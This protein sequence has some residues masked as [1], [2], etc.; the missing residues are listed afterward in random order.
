MKN[1]DILT[2]DWLRE[3]TSEEVI[4]VLWREA[5]AL[6]CPLA[7]WSSPDEDSRH[8]LIDL[9]DKVS[10]VHP[11]VEELPPGFLFTPYE[12][13]FT[14][15]EARDAK[16]SFLLK[17]HLYYATDS[18]S[19]LHLHTGL[20]GSMAERAEL[21]LK[22]AK[23]NIGESRDPLP[24]YVNKEVPA[25]STGREDYLAL[26]GAA[27]NEIKE[28][29]VQK[30]VCGRAKS[31]PLPENFKALAYFNKLCAN[32]PNAFVSFVS[33]P[34]T[35]SWIGATPEVLVQISSDK[36]F[37]T[38]ALAGTQPAT[39]VQS[40]SDAVWRQKEIEEQALVSRYIINCFKKIRLREFEEW[41]PRTVLAGNLMHLRT[42][43]SVDMEAAD[44][45]RLGSTMLELLHPTSA[46]CGMPRAEAMVFLAEKEQLNRQFFA[47][48]LGPVNIREEV[49]LFVNLRCMQ[50]LEKEVVLYAGAGITGDSL[51]EKEW[52][53]T[54]HKLNTLA[55]LL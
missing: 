25:N 51:P 42:D 55:S 7:L 3:H 44:F 36:I 20:S 40:P 22:N 1:A 54:E 31:L 19:M 37:R 43:F 21:L 50:L 41:G 28:G 11:V 48:F 9:S 8:L 24:F 38:M 14:S 45:P 5:F 10:R 46:V 49:H 17:A 23:T 18:S 34:G 6:G 35:G 53:E 33:I 2:Q 30:L 15:P 4:E 32:Y 26:A 13:D 39:A 29:R 12:A 27:I 52:Q 16:H 47:G